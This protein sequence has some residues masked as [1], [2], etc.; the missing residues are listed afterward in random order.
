[1]TTK[2]DLLLTRDEEDDKKGKKKG[3][4]NNQYTPAMGDETPY[5]VREWRAIQDRESDG[6]GE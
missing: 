4:Y 5:G 3:D 1:M 6:G 2:H